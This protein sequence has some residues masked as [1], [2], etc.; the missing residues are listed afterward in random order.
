[1]KCATVFG[2]SIND[3]TTP[4]YIDTIGIGG[5][6]ASYGYLVKSG[7]YYGIMEA[8]SKGCVDGGGRSIGYTCAS[9]RSVKGNSFLSDTVVSD[10]IYDRLRGL[11]SNTDVYIFQKGGIGTLSELFLVLD[12]VRK[13]KERPVILLVGDFWNNVI[14]GVSSMM[15][16]DELSMLVILSDYRDISNYLS[17]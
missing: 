12:C 3:T 7:G 10:D 9:F 2:G 4:E 15:T 5:I 17:M 16:S 14:G 6:L 13:L 8:A 1:M 11:I